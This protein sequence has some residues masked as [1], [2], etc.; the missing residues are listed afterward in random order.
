MY[1]AVFKPNNYLKFSHFATWNTFGQQRLLFYMKS[2]MHYL[3]LLLISRYTM[4]MTSPH[5]WELHKA[6][7]SRTFTVVLKDYVKINGK[8]KGSVA[9]TRIPWTPQHGGALW[10]MRAPKCTNT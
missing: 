1:F 10:V 4:C 8:I 3:I 2:D 7:S 9:Q 6:T 5:F